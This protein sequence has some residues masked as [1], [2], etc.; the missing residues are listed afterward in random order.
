MLS[1]LFLCG[2]FPAAGAVPLDVF[3]VEAAEAGSRVDVLVRSDPPFP[4][5]VPADAGVFQSGPSVG[6]RAPGGRPALLLVRREGARTYRLDGPFEWP[7]SPGVRTFRGEDRR[8]LFGS[9][10]AAAELAFVFAGG[11]EIPD[12][13]CDGDGDGGWRCLGVPA[14]FSGRIVACAGGRAVG[15]AAVHPEA[16]GETTFQRTA[17]AAAL[18]ATGPEAEPVNATARVVRPVSAGGL[19]FAA[20]PLARVAPLRDGILWVEGGNAP[21]RLVEVRASGYAT[22]RLSLDE[23]PSPCGGPARVELAR[24]LDLRGTVV[25]PEGEPAVSATVLVRSD[26]PAKDPTVFGDA[27]TDEWG[28]FEIPDLASR[29][30][31]IL[32]CHPALGC[33]EES[34][35][36]GDPVRV[37]LGEEGVY[38]G[39]ALSRT[40]VP[41]AGADVRIVPTAEAWTAASDR[42]RKLPLQTK[43]GL[44]GRFRIA[45]P[46]RGDFLVEV[47]G[48]SGGVARVRVRR[49]D[50][51]PDVTDL[52]DVRLVAPVEFTARVRGCPGGWLT[53]AGPISGETSLPDVSRFRLDPNGAAAVRLSE[54]GAWTAWAACSGEIETLDPALLPDVEVLDGGEI[55]FARGGRSSE[56]G[57]PRR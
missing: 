16:E 17:F 8:T 37:V 20:D 52:G 23:L 31:R 7:R 40:G 38:S 18:R 57:E 1:L 47:R 25:G 43:S 44:D 48:T 13:L 32:A 12:P 22:R 5:W 42:L 54:P 24:A 35:T 49:T 34:V 21:D 45:A 41:E 2:S 9:H 30:Y 10:P 33:R 46:G 51:S 26:E 6:L 3:P 55:E 15:V 11:A 29:A 39:R 36:P 50:L 53:L 56:G 27:T 14:R 19:A 28:A 4:R